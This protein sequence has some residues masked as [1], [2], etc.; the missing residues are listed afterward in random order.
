LLSKKNPRFLLKAGIFSSRDGLHPT[1][2]GDLI[3]A[4]TVAD[5]LGCA[6]RS[7]GLPRMDSGEFRYVA[8]SAAASESLAVDSA[9]WAA[10][11][12]EQ[13]YTLSLRCKVGNGAQDGWQRTQGLTLVFGK[14]SPVQQG[15]LTISESGVLWLG[16]SLL[17]SAD[18]SAN[19][20]EIRV[21]WH[22][23]NQGA[24][25]ARG[26]YIWLGDRLIGEAL[27]AAETG[28][29]PAA[30]AVSA[31]AGVPVQLEWLRAEAGAYAPPA[32]TG[33]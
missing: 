8:S 4:E 13:G 15:S 25:I 18:M 26:F 11:K 27:P 22:P 24:G 7:A 14:E 6:G 31:A 9:A 21:V 30:Y 17:Y 10:V 32:R 28:S 2:Q 16:T 23:G 20:E 1:P 3:I 5:A 12:A 29:A 33:R 19:D